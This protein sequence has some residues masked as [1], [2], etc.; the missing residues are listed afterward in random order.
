MSLLFLRFLNYVIK[1]WC[2]ILL[3]E[4]NL[5][6]IIACFVEIALECEIMVICSASLIFTLTPM[7]L[8]CI[9]D[10]T[11]TAFVDSK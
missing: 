11:H 8:Y 3:A 2:F 4:V 5:L 6:F 9:Y 10:S 1:L 7:V